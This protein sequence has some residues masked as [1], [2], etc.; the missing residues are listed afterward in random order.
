VRRIKKSSSEL[1]RSCGKRMRVPIMTI[2]VG[3]KAG[4][5]EIQ[6]KTVDVE[7]RVLA[8]VCNKESLNRE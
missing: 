8:D 5:V 3:E 6:M 1:A 7:L 4:D 2:E